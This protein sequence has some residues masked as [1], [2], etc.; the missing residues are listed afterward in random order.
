MLDAMD[1]SLEKLEW[2]LIPWRP[3]ISDHN[4]LVVLRNIVFILTIP[5]TVC[6]WACEVINIYN[7]RREFRRQKHI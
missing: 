7:K 2:K 5:V 1:C 6:M 3:Q 4:R